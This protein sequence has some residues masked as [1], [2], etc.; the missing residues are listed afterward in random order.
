MQVFNPGIHITLGIGFM[1]YL[2]QIVSHAAELTDMVMYFGSESLLNNRIHDAPS[3]A[4]TDCNSGLQCFCFER[5]ILLS[6]YLYIYPVTFLL[7]VAFY[8]AT[9]FAL[10][11]HLLLVF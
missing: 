9:T 6:R 1:G 10:S 7:T 2:I 5:I 4:F 11:F 8:G 3:E